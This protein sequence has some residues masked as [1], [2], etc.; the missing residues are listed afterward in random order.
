VP[1]LPSNSEPAATCRPDQ[2]FGLWAIEETRFRRSLELV[3]GVDLDTLR[4]ESR[5]AAADAAGQP[6]YRTSSDGIARMDISGPLTKYP[7]S[8]QARSAARPCCARARRCA[9]LPAIPEVT[10]IMLVIDSPGGTVHSTA[11]LAEAIRQAD[12]RKPV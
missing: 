11:D 3:Q 7:T 12:T 8:F 5:A 1:P 4:A 6:L 9:P 2:L 10:G